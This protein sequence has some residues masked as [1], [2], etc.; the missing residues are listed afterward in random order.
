[1][2]SGIVQ[3]LF[4]AIEQI[5]KGRIERVVLFLVTPVPDI[6]QQVVVRRPIG[7]DLLLLQNI[8]AHEI[9]PHQVHGVLV[10]VGVV[11]FLVPVVDLS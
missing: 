9:E 7:D 2:F 11:L 3:P 4:Q 10:Q 8:Q 6:H 1:M 5:I